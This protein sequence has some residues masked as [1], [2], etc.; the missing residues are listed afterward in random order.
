MSSLVDSVV[1]AMDQGTGSNVFLN[2]DTPEEV[3]DT[4][5][6][7]ADDARDRDMKNEGMAGA[8]LGG[9]AG[10]ALTKTPS[11]VLSGAKLGSK[12]Q[13]AFSNKEEA[14]KKKMDKC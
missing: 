6:S 5:I 12:I 14:K 4:D 9:I 3:T 11:G 2:V 10:G 13:D 8:A 1:K 7:R